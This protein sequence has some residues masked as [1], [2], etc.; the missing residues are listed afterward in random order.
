MGPLSMRF[1]TLDMLCV[2]PA[3]TSLSWNTLV[4][5]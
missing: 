3:E 5:Y 1:P 2:I 4:V